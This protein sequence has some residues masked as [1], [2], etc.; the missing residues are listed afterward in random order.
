MKLLHKIA[1]FIY[2]DLV[3][4]FG[5][6]LAVPHWLFHQPIVQLEHTYTEFIR[7]DINFTEKERLL[8]QRAARNLEWFCNGFL[9]IDIEFDWDPAQEIPENTGIILRVPATDKTIADADGY[10]KNTVLGLCSWTKKHSTVIHLVHD[11]LQDANTFRTTV[12]HEL[13]HYMG[14]GH[15]KKPSIMYKENYTRVLYMTYK[16]A[17]EFAK[18]FGLRPEYLRYFKL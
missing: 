17:V 5:L 6:D 9:E 12:L 1:A 10:F 4:D 18:R 11:R 15:T 2:C 13:G 7:A 8:I 14:M 3:V 16:D